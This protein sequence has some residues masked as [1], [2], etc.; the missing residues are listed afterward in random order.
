MNAN[1]PLTKLSAAEA[2][3]AIA[4]ESLHERASC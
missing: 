1:H 4:A 3:L 2:S